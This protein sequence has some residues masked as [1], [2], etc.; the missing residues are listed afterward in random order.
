MNVISDTSAK[1]VD[2][3]TTQNP[4]LPGERRIL[5]VDDDKDALQYSMD[6]LTAAG[7]LVEGFEDGAAGWKALQSNN[8]DLVLT[9]NKMPKMTGIEMIEKLRSAHMEIPVI[10]ATGALPVHEFA[11]N[12]WLRPD[13]MLQ[14][15]FSGDQLLEAVRA[16][17]GTGD[18]A[19]SGKETLLTQ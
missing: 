16:F 5:L 1:K 19:E 2:L 9:D 14:R 7:Y 18:G 6:V 11:R 17:L 8:Y 13:A 10:L 12:P 3:T 4:A 15:P